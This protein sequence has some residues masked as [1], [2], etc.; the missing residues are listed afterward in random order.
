MN[1]NRRDASR[2]G[3][4][5]LSLQKKFDLQKNSVSFV[6]LQKNFVVGFDAGLGASLVGRPSAHGG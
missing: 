5:C 2:A 4:L 3:E 6:S 1:V